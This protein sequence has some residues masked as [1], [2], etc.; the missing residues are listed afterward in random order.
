MK[1]LVT[2]ANS[3][4]GHHIVFELL[5]RLHDVRII[6]R[7][8]NNIYFDKEKVQI[9][10]GNFYDE[11]LLNE[12]L[13][14]CEAVIHIAAIT[15]TDLLNYKDYKSINF[16][17]CKTLLHVAEAKSINKIVFISTTNTIGYGCKNLKADE[18]WLFEYPFTESFYA[19][20]KFKAERVF[21]QFAKNHP[22]KHV[23]I[24]NPGFMIGSYDVKPSSGKLILTGFNKRFV[25]LPNGGKNFV[26][27]K[28]VAVASC[29]ALTMGIS[30]E[31]YLATGN[32]NISFRKFFKKMKNIY[33]Y[34]QYMIILPGFL[35]KFLGGLGDIIRF[36]RIKTSLSS[37]NINQLLIKEYYANQKA[38]D[39]LQMPETSLEEAI[40]QAIEWFKS[41]GKIKT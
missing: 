24:I 29:N 13:E 22:E 7:N 20:S 1:I 41:H 30:G 15:S 36:L 10:K 19:K 23:I 40:K 32:D 27:V 35:F 33:G 31:R 18:K 2:G 28:D 8:D 9:F 26:P 6:V 37:R 39:Q 16:D 3:L 34:T 5:N 17:A 38:I 12:A 14:G 25:I 4:L 11:T 21:I